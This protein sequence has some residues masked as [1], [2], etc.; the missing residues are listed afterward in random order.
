MTTTQET[1]DAL[2]FMYD[3]TSCS[4]TRIGKHFGLAPNTVERYIANRDNKP[5][6]PI[7][8]SAR[9]TGPN[10]SATNRGQ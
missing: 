4:L 10:N 8:E 3:T 7:P 6:P 5:S 2:R 1:I 9:W